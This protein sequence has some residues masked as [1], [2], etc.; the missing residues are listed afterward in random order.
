MIRLAPLV[1]VSCAQPW[2]GPVCHRYG[3][4][5]Y[6]NTAH[7]DRVGLAIEGAKAGGQWLY[8]DRGAEVAGRVH[9]NLSVYALDRERTHA[10]ALGWSG[11]WSVRYA[12]RNDCAEW[13]VGHEL[14]HVFGFQLGEPDAMEHDNQFL[15]GPLSISQFAIGAVRADCEGL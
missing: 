13:I 5:I 4:A 10:D 11:V 15:F 3:A 2:P 7:C 12:T 8:Q 1:L 9:G 6:G 14:G